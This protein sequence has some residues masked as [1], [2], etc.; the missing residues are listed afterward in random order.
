[1]ATEAVQLLQAILQSMN[2]L[3]QSFATLKPQGPDTMT[4]AEALAQRNRERM[5]RELD[6]FERQQLSGVKTSIFEAA[7]EVKSRR[8]L[9]KAIK[10]NTDTLNKISKSNATSVEKARAMQRALEGLSYAVEEMSDKD[11]PKFAKNFSNATGSLSGFS[12]VIMKGG[13]AIREFIDNITDS[14]EATAALRT[15]MEQA[16]ATVKSGMELSAAERRALSEALEDEAKARKAAGLST[17][18]SLAAFAQTL[19]SNATLG[20]NQF[21]YA[22]NRLKIAEMDRDQQMSAALETL[23]GAA[24]GAAKSL[25]KAQSGIKAHTGALATGVGAVLGFSA[26]RGGGDDAS[27]IFGDMMSGINTNIN[28]GWMKTMLQGVLTG[29]SPQN[30]RE[31]Y[32]DAGM[33]RGQTSDQLARTLETTNPSLDQINAMGGIDQYQV[34]YRTTAKIIDS[35]GGSI[36]DI[37][38]LTNNMSMY[39]DELMRTGAVNR[40]EYATFASSLME[41]VDTFAALYTSGHKSAESMAKAAQKTAAMGA[42]MGYTTQQ[43]QKFAEQAGSLLNSTQEDLQKKAR[44]VIIQSQVLGIDPREAQ[45]MAMKILQRRANDGDF[46]KF[47]AMASSAAKD[48]VDLKRQQE[49][50]GGVASASVLARLQQLAANGIDVNSLSKTGVQR[51]ANI[52]AQSPEQRAALQNII[53]SANAQVGVM[54]KTTKNLSLFDQA[55]SAVINRMKGV[56]QNGFVTT[57]MGAAGPLLAGLAGALFTKMLGGVRG[58][59]S[60]LGGLFKLAP[61]AVTTGAV[62]GGTGVATAG[63][64]AAGAGM[65]TRLGPKLLKGGLTGLAGG[66]V[67]DY[68]DDKLG[69]TAALEG[70]IGHSASYLTSALKGGAAGAAGG[71][72]FGG[73]GAIPGALIGAIAGVA[74]QAISDALGSDDGTTNTPEAASKATKQ[75]AGTLIDVHTAIMQTGAQ[76]VAELQKLNRGME[77]LVGITASQYAPD[78]AK[79]SGAGMARYRTNVATVGDYIIR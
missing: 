34:M 10:L 38:T 51:E 42:M 27:S 73:I 24:D 7:K 46:A 67:L 17:D 49:V 64:A 16:E 71:A 69:A 11:L 60:R 21:A 40:E 23:A 37:N 3:N 65:M 12:D 18:S 39:G 41:G 15:M 2:A 62:T 25:I 13:P 52:A 9:Q 77:A 45:N 57:L 5:R 36:K 14:A 6:K 33:G 4:A 56:G 26:L 1:M 75:S 55:L 19:D 32:A 50:G 20:V 44:E 22:L 70:K 43:M 48:L 53:D 29:M 59:F 28:S 47:E 58:I 8:E 74:G 61:S 76:S 54:E 66:L 72:L 79:R 35:I 63:T 68:A 78:K 31:M 30:L